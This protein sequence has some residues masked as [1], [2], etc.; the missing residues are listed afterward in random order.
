MA[1]AT[2]VAEWML[3]KLHASG[4]LSQEDTVYEVA[5]R[6]GNEF[7][8]WNA[9]GNLAIAKQVLSEF[10]RLTG[11][12]VVWSRSDR[13]WRFRQKYDQPSRGQD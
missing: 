11:D 8:Y 13:C 3:A 5:Q 1:T 6:F 2:Q 4:W 12:T 9:N 10:R 7:T